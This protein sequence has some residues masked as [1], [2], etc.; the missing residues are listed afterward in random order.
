MFYSI[1]NKNFIKRIIPQKK[2][3]SCVSSSVAHAIAI[4][5]NRFSYNSFF[6]SILFIYYNGR[7]DK[8]T[9][10][11][12]YIQNIFKGVQKYGIVPEI[13]FPYESSN[14]LVKPHD[15]LYKFSEQ[16][17]IEFQFK[18]FSSTNAKQRHILNFIREHLWNG[19]LIIADIRGPKIDHTILIYGI[20]EKN[21]MFLCYDPTITIITISFYNDIFDKKDLYAIRCKFPNKIPNFILENQQLEKDKNN[22]KE[23][24]EPHTFEIHSMSRKF[25]CIITGQNLKA[26]LINFFLQKHDKNRNILFID[27]NYENM[28]EINQVI[29]DIKYGSYESFSNSTLKYLY[30]VQQNFEIFSN[31]TNK[32]E[33][34][35]VKSLLN[36]ILKPIGLDTKS[37]NLNYQ[38]VYCKKIENIKF[39][40]FQDVLEQNVSNKDNIKLYHMF[41]SKN[42]KGLDL[43]LPYYVVLKIIIS[44]LLSKNK[45]YIKNYKSFLDKFLPHYQNVKLGTFLM[46][47]ASDSNFIYLNSNYNVKDDQTIVL[48]QGSSIENSYS[49]KIE[50]SF[51]ELYDTNYFFPIKHVDFKPIS[52]MNLFFICNRKE[53]PEIQTNEIVGNTVYKDNVIKVSLYQQEVQKIIS[54]KPPN[55]YMNILYDIS[56][57]QILERYCDERKPKFFMLSPCSFSY[58]ISTLPESQIIQKSFGLDNTIHSLNNNFFGSSDIT[59]YNLSIVELLIYFLQ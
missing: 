4:L 18:K 26:S 33:E 31:T 51:E 22:V 47:Q 3:N 8:N 45:I 29:N 59:E 2:D 44:P 30:E 40:S 38:I 1:S 57:Y 21:N 5:M 14:I 35:L 13:L 27:R 37:E 34:A 17:P 15:S 42:F 48:F 19:D 11:G 7:E 23:I 25:D 50:V 12:A 9:D 49:D 55:I 39:S 46:T 36:D 28:I 24:I 56:N 54:E 58:P 6:P 53:E 52:K 43:S 32:K 41:L 10:S 20:D 16:F